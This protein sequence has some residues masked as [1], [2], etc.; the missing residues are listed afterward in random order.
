MISKRGAS[1]KT[2]RLFLT[3]NPNWQTSGVWFKNCAVGRNEMSKWTSV[4]AKTIGLDS[5]K[6]KFTNHSHRATTV[7]QLAKNGV[8]ENQLTK[9]TGHGNVNSI[10]PYLQLDRDFHEELIKKMRGDRTMSE[11][12]VSSVSTSASTSVV[13]GQRQSS[14]GAV[15]NNYNNCVFNCHNF[16]N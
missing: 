10:K 1:I 2:N 14:S 12:N 3:P 13:S 9:I 11:F 15:I 6:F 16:N 4:S 8:N 5:K 7:T